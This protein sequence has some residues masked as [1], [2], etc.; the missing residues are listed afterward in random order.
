M[1]TCSA[2]HQ[3]TA[4]SAP[5]CR[6][7]S[8]PPWAPQLRLLHCW[9]QQPVLRLLLLLLWMWMQTSCGHQ[10]HLRGRRLQCRLQWHALASL[11]LGCLLGGRLYACG[12][13]CW[14]AWWVVRHTAQPGLVSRRHSIAAEGAM[15]GPCIL[16]PHLLCQGFGTAC[17][18]SCN[19][20]FGYPAFSSGHGAVH[21][22]AVCRA[23]NTCTMHRPG[24]WC[25]S[26][27][28]RAAHAASE[29]QRDCDEAGSKHLLLVTR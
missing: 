13:A 18:S 10:Q 12:P 19:I 14:T 3:L 26:S 28:S 4:P 29:T 23:A 15:Q 27:C 2:H 7:M 20:W 21:G 8:P 5:Q 22:S 9:W 16:Q 25:C 1:R 17:V 24:Q 6:P 11:T